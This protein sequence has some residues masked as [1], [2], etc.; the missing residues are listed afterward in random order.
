MKTPSRIEHYHNGWIPGLRT[1]ILKAFDEHE[2]L[3]CLVSKWE[4]NNYYKYVRFIVTLKQLGYILTEQQR[5]Q[6]KT[7]PFIDESYI[8][9]IQKYHVEY[10]ANM[11]GYS[12]DFLNNIKSKSKEEQYKFG[13]D[14]GLEPHE[15]DRVLNNL[16]R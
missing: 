3:I 5:K 8:P 16:T 13:Y 9:H 10:L 12:N 11:T 7:P 4:E 1:W 2:N 14:I 15:M 6:L